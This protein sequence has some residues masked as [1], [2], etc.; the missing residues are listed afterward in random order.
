M[1]KKSSKKP[2]S[3]EFDYDTEDSGTTIAQRGQR[4]F[5][6]EAERH[7]KSLYVMLSAALY[8]LYRMADV[9][10]WL[11]FC[12]ESYWSRRIQRNRPK[13]QATDRE[14]ATFVSVYMFA[15]KNEVRYDRAWKY[16]RIIEFCH[17]EQVKPKDMVSFLKDKG[18]IDK[19]LSEMSEGRKSPVAETEVLPSLAKL[20]ERDEAI[21]QQEDQGGDDPSDDDNKKPK[22]PSVTKKVLSLSIEVTESQFQMAMNCPIGGSQWLK[23]S[24][25]ASPGKFKVLRAKKLRDAKK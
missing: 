18:G 25:E 10:E 3:P 15:G 9:T 6:Q 24:R 4:Y 19:L 21:D 11:E 17:H 12:E 7:N 16:G 22:K 8:V 14:K 1:S 13:E 5:N 2:S 23:Y 20:T